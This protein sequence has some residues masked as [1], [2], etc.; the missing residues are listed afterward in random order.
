MDRRISFVEEEQ[1][2]QHG[3][4]M[5]R[6]CEIHIAYGRTSKENQGGLLA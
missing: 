6:E 4:Y 3:R 2:L 1:M 5:H